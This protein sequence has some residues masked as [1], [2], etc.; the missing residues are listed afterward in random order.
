MEAVPHIGT[1]R[2]SLPVAI[3]RLYENAIDWE[4]LPYVHRSTFSR[5]DCLEAGS[6]GFRAR[7]WRRAREDGQA[8]VLELRLDRDCRRWIT[9]TVEGPGRGSEVWTHAFAIDERR[10]DIVV[11]FFAPGQAHRTE[12]LGRFYRELY[13]GLYDEDVA[14][15]AL[16]QQRLREASRD[17]S[18]ES[19]EHYLLGRLEDVRA[20]LPLVIELAGQRFRVVE[21]GGELFAHT[22]VCPHLLGPLDNAEVMTDGSIECPWHG[23]RFDLRTGACRG[24]AELR[25]RP[26]VAIRIDPATSLVTAVSG[27]EP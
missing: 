26:M 23:Y 22:V 6:W 15:M 21:V 18:K 2:R 27:K 14:M 9:R 16:R 8:F 24:R 10:T 11:D 19:S 3:E 17:Q 1:Y 4:H 13:A 25:L 5:I 7:V 12:T 20:R